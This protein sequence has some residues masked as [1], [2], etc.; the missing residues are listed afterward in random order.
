MTKAASVTVSVWR[1]ALP[2]SRLAALRAV[3]SPDERVRADRFSVASAARDFVA[4]RGVLRE[5]LAAECGCGPHAVS[6]GVGAR[7]KPYLKHP[8]PP[9][10]FNLSHSGGYCALAVGAFSRI[11]VDI[12]ALRDDVGDITANVFSMREAETYAALAP[13]DRM[14]AFF[15]GWV[16]KEAFLKAT[17]EGLAG[18]LKSIE[19]NLTAESEINPIAIRGDTASLANWRF[20]G[21]DVSETIVGAVAVQTTSAIELRVSFID[22]S[23]PI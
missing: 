21:F 17:G 8:S 13:A 20:R 15:R 11:G 7:G 9:F 6:I 10:A 2:P 16:A 19:L 23:R 14:R 4:S 3:L 5:L 1:L 22:P 12:E 18:G